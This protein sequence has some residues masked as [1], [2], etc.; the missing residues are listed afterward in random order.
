MANDLV[1]R[2]SNTK[3]DLPSKFKAD[4]VNCYGVKLLTSGYSY[5]QVRRILV[6][7]AKGY[8][9]K[10]GRR[11]S[12]GGRLHRTAQESSGMRMKKKL[13]GKSNWFRDKKKVEEE[14]QVKAGTKAGRGTQDPADKSLRT[15]TVLFVEQTPKGALASKLREQ[16]Q[17][18]APTLGSGWWRDL[19]GTSSPTPPT[20]SMGRTPVWEDRLYHV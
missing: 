3:E 1:R 7:G 2:L 12:K 9:T 5:E 14:N 10:L 13:L 18:L 6:T 15:R 19:E 17:H 8:L 4:V 20:S 16:L 11:T